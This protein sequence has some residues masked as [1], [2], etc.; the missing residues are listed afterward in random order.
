VKNYLKH[1]CSIHY[2]YSETNGE[3]ANKINN[4]SIMV[5]MP[6]PSHAHME[7]LGNLMGNGL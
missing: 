3:H 5:A 7:G 6:Y 4:A 1:K 2:I